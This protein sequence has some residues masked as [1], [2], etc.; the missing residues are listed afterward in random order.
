MDAIETVVATLR[1][2]IKERE[3]AIAS[4]LRFRESNLQLHS[5]EFKGTWTPAQRKAASARAKAQWRKRKAE[6]A[7]NRVKVTKVT[8]KKK[9]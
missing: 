9:G 6:R 8:A 4:L 1:N 2:Q 5:Y 7:Q 3:D